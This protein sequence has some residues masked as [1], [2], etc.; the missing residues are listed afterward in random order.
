M[1]VEDVRLLG[2]LGLACLELPIDRAK[3]KRWGVSV[4]D[5]E[6]VIQAAV[7]GRVVSRMVEGE[8]LFDIVLRWPPSLVRG[9]E[10]LLDLPVEVSNNVARPDLGNPLV[11]Q[12]RLRLRDLVTPVGKDGEPDPKGPF[13]RPGVG[14]IFRENGQRFV[15]I[16]FRSGG[17]SLDN[18]RATVNP[19][20]APAFRTEWIAH[21][22]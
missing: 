20:I 19:L 18:V 2:G 1:G 15:A 9:E 10:G 14:A 7:G 21:L 4:G 8:K 22:P 5:V 12:P 3:C 17:A 6:D 11:G 16:R 13:V